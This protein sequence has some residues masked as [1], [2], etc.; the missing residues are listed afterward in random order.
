MKKTM[1]LYAMILT[2]GHSYSQTNIYHPFPDSNTIWIGEEQTFDGIDCYIYDHY[3]MFIDGDTTIGL[4]TYHKLYQNGFKYSNCPPPGFYYFNQLKG[5]FRQDI[6]NKKVYIN[7]NGMDTLAYDLNLNAGD[8]L[9]PSFLNVMNN[10]VESVDSILVGNSYRKMFWLSNQYTTNYLRL[11][12]GIGSDHGL[13]AP[14]AEN[15][16]EYS[17]DLYCIYEDGNVLWQYYTNGS[18]C[19][20][21]TSTEDKLEYSKISVQP[22]PFRTQTLITIPDNYSDL[23]LV[24]FNSY[25]RK[26]K[27]GSLEKGSYILYREDL[28]KGL[29]IIQITAQNQLVSTEKVIITD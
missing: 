2:I 12:E 21:I 3:N 19:D 17:N 1:L 13:L 6:P 4:Y 20:L 14:M 15:W 28:P 27:E 9:P 11:I 8:T 24:I 22:N 25:G 23:E 26:V 5:F 16:S 7:Y 29:Y 10:Y 18:G